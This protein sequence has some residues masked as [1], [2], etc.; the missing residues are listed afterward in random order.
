MKA[1]I[2]FRRLIIATIDTTDV[3][4]VEAKQIGSDIQVQCNFI[5]GSDAL[6]CM[7]VL[8]G[9]AIN[10][11]VNVTRCG[12]RSCSVLILNSKSLS[13]Y[14]E[15]FA[16]DIESDGSVGT[17]SISG[18]LMDEP[19]CNSSAV[20]CAQKFSSGRVISTYYII[21]MVM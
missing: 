18:E 9:D 20:S 12:T 2:S 19:I 10:T 5:S 21:C 14:C 11:T 6:G 16:F 1:Q 3:Q 8:V 4:Q 13:C 17:L 15:V 7:V